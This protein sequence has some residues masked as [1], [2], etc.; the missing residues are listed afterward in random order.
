MA[1]VIALPTKLGRSPTGSRRIRRGCGT[2]P[3]IAHAFSTWTR[4]DAVLA[5]LAADVDRI[6]SRDIWVVPCIDDGVEPGGVLVAN[7]LPLMTRS[8]FTP[9]DARA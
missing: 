3:V 4:S 9:E 2:L 5:A 7:A 1:R 6:L 8:T